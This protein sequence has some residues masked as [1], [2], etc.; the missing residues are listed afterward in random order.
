MQSTKTTIKTK[1]ISIKSA[2]AFFSVQFLISISM[3]KAEQRGLDISLFQA[4]KLINSSI[5]C[6]QSSISGLVVNGFI[7]VVITTIERRFGLQS[8]KTG[9][10]A[11]GEKYYATLDSLSPYLIDNLM[12]CDPASY[13]YKPKFV[14]LLGYDIASFFCL[15]PVSYFGGRVGASKPKWVGWGVVIMGLGFFTFSLPHFLV[16]PYRA[17]IPENN[18]CGSAGNASLAECSA[19]VKQKNGMEDLSWNVWFFFVAQL[20]HGIGDADAAFELP[21]DLNSILCSFQAHRRFTPSASRTSTITFPRR[22]R[23]SI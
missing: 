23:V 17:E 1:K 7:N 11:S 20:L 6:H 12:T 18:V 21:L 3:V 8:R 14:F 15:I 5:T 16:G 19:G 22:C 9:F 10:I 2:N 13:F 4:I